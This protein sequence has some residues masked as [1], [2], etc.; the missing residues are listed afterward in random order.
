MPAR[1]AGPPAM[2]PV[3]SGGAPISSTPMPTDPLPWRVSL[4]VSLATGLRK[5]VW[6]SCRL[7][8]IVRMAA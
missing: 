1:S 4:I 6:Q 2:T 7:F 8:A 3:T 5:N